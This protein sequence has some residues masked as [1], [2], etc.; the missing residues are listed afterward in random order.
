[1]SSLLNSKFF[2]F[3][4]WEDVQ[5]RLL[6]CKINVYIMFIQI[7]INYFK[8]REIRSIAGLSIP[9]FEKWF[10]WMCIITHS[11]DKT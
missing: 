11:E 9:D 10:A 5:S 1:M 7:V 2:E 3:E 4:L 8:Q 6:G